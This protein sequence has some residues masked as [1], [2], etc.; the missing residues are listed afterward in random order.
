MADL[1][2]GMSYIKKQREYQL[3]PEDYYSGSDA[4]IYFGDV[5]VDELMHIEYKLREMVMPIYGYNS[6]RFD[7]AARGQRIVEGRF[8]IA[9]RESGFMFH[10]LEHIGQIEEKANPTLSYLMDSSSPSKPQWVAGLEE[11]LDNL[12]NREYG[13]TTSN[14]STSGR[15]SSN[16][17]VSQTAKV[18]NLNIG[19]TGDDVKKVQQILVSGRSKEMYK[20][21]EPLGTVPLKNNMARNKIKGHI[22]KGQDVIM[23]KFRL[24]TYLFDTGLMKKKLNITSDVFDA[25][26]ENAVKLFQKRFTN[27]AIDGIVGPK[28]KAE[29]T[30]GVSVTGEYDAPTKLCV[31]RF[32][33]AN[34]LTVDG[35]AGLQTQKKMGLV[36]SS[37]TQSSSPVVT[38]PVVTNPVVSG[39]AESN[40]SAE[41]K[42]AEYEADIWG[43]QSKISNLQ[44][45]APYF[46]G[47]GW[48]ASL[49][50]SGFD[51]YI[52]FGPLKEA[53]RAN[54][55]KLPNQVSFNTTIKAIR[56]VQ[57][58]DVEMVL[59]ASGEPIAETYYFIAQDLD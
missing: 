1:I 30:K 2:R 29:L 57:L 47:Q 34:G 37:S 45:N 46:Y 26:T 58:T 56:N 21:I 59:N 53:I 24:N 6:Y 43:N 50:I 11:N 33:K 17:K 42:Y 39:V 13:A 32:Q 4:S 20:G 28:T 31:M 8:T 10:L 35:M 18:R 19:M 41:K 3:F 5:F 25:E 55:N 15:S 44:K 48:S 51:I 49:Q 27:L 9:F 7:V 38:N 36:S 22:N 23:L 52:N 54:N 12:L 40:G 16:A 14:A